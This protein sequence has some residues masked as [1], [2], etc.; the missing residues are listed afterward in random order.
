LSNMLRL[1]AC[2]VS[3]KGFTIKDIFLPQSILSWMDDGIRSSANTGLTLK[4]N[5][6]LRKKHNPGLGGNSTGD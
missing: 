2:V 3:G 1:A 4:M 5:R 6:L